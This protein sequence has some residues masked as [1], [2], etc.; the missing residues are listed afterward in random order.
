MEYLNL[1]YNRVAVF[2]V[3]EILACS[4]MIQHNTIKAKQAVIKSFLAEVT[5]IVILHVASYIVL[6][7]DTLKTSV[8]SLLYEPNL[9]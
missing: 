2:Q 1:C 4:D 6:C 8:N 7:I 3:L 9:N 5:K